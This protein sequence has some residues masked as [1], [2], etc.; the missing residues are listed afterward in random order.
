M[1]RL[2]GIIG[3]FGKR[4]LRVTWAPMVLCLGLL[5]GCV[6]YIVLDT[7]VLVMTDKLIED[8]AIGFGTGQD[9]RITNIG[10]GPYCA[11]PEEA[12]AD[13]GGFVPSPS[14][15]CRQELGEITCYDEDLGDVPFQNTQPPEGG[16][17]RGDPLRNEEDA[18]GIRLIP[19]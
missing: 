18:G 6:E 5:G 12:G 4:R 3:L 17:E 2:C 15:N 7:A 16:Q 10:K 14:T 1:T 9:C 13:A 8:H 19:L 11:A